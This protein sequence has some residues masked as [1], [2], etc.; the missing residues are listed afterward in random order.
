MQLLMFSN[1]SG[2]LF[3]I[4]LVNPIAGRVEQNVSEAVFELICS[5]LIIQIL[6]SDTDVIT[7]C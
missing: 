1:T 6:Q 4:V 5:R 2:I 3:L 7:E